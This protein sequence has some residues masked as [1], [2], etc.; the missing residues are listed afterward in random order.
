MSDNE[1]QPL[2]AGNIQCVVCGSGFRD[3]APDYRI[4]DGSGL[5]YG[6]TER[7]FYGHC[8]N[9]HRLGVLLTSGRLVVEVLR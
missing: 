3:V 7:R 6:W 4:N 9:G 5:D 8:R 2:L 1:R